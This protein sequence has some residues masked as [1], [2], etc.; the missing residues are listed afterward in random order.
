L[1]L[2]PEACVPPI[3]F[4]EEYA[5]VDR[6]NGTDGKLVRSNLES[7]AGIA[8]GMESTGVRKGSLAVPEIDIQGWERDFQ[9]VHVIHV[10]SEKH[11]PKSSPEE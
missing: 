6:V 10:R 11:Q 3:N 4:E 1:D 5:T 2:G 8:E 7:V 9:G